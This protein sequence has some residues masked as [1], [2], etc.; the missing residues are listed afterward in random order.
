VKA[1][2]HNYL[3]FADDPDC[4]FFNSELE[5]VRRALTVSLHGF[6][7]STQGLLYS[8]IN[9]QWSMPSEWLAADHVRFGDS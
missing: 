2:I 9:D 4:H 8:D 7:D 5:A 6:V 3:Q 1:G